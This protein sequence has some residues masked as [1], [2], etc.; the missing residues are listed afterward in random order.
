[1]LKKT[2]GEDAR[3]NDLSRL[4]QAFIT[5]T[6]IWSGEQIKKNLPMGFAYNGYIKAFSYY[7]S[8]TSCAP[9]ETG[10]VLF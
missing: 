4:R 3:L 6:N 8:S 9:G 2:Q 10:I 1:M 7:F 5:F